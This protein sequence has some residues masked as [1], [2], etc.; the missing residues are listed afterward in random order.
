MAAPHVAGLAARLSQSQPGISSS[1]ISDALTA[2]NVAGGNLTIAN[3]VED[4]TP[5]TTTTSPTTTTVPTDDD[6]TT[7]TTVAPSTTTTAP[8]NNRSPN[9]KAPGQ[10]KKV[11]TPKEFKLGYQ[12]VNDT[13]VLVATWNDDRS[14][15][16]YSV[17]CTASAP[18][19]T[20]VATTRF[21]IE[22]SATTLNSEES[23]QA[24]LNLSPTESMF[25]WIVAYIGADNSARSNVARINAAP[26]ATAPDQPQGNPQN[27][28][29]PN[30]SRVPGNSNSN[31]PSPNNN[32]GTTTPIT[33]SP[34]N[35]PATPNNN[36]SGK[37]K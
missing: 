10:N 24:T 27:P 23:L 16:S 15:Q 35:S 3:F 31:N 28:S 17:E 8:R 18:T 11:V 5:V 9:T 29:T 32:T 4:E 14:P 26:R 36:N 19:P 30:T 22:Q 13:L 37:K 12:N 21:I 7:T 33:S 2:S 25:C 6:T 34:G 1:G 20:S